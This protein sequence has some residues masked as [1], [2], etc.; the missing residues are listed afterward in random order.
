MNDNYDFV[1]VF[2]LLKECHG[3]LTDYESRFLNS[4][5]AQK[6]K[7][8]LK[9]TDLLSKIQK[10]YNIKDLDQYRYVTGQTG[11][12]KKSKSRRNRKKI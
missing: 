11:S 1:K 12:G 5:V 2:T 7:Q 8:T 3:K 10:K 4:L 9:Q 6:F